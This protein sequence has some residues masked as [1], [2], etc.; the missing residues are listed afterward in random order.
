MMLYGI[1]AVGVLLFFVII[2]SGYVKASPDEAIL[3]SGLK[4]TAKIVIGKAAI[5]IPFLERKDRL[6]LK[7]MKIDVKTR[8]SVPTNEFINVNVDAVVTVKISSDPALIKLAAENFLNQKEQY[9]VD[10]VT[11]VLEGNIREIVGTMT[12]ENM[13]SDRQEFAKKV[14][15]NA[16]PD[17]RKMGIE[18]VSFN[19]QNFSDK[20]GI[21]EDLGI[22]NTTKIKKNAAIVRA[23]SERDVN[24]AQAMADKESNDAKVSA[25]QEIAI[26]QNQLAIKKAE[27]KKT[28]DIKKAEADMAYDIQ[29]EEQR[30]TMEI[31]SA[32][33]NLAKQEKEIELKEREVQIKEKTLEAEIKKK[34]EADR[35]AKQ[36]QADANLYERQKKAEAEKFEA[37]QQAEA[38]KAKAEAERVAKEEEAIGIK[39]VALAEADGIRAKG[40]AE[41]EGIDKKAE[42][43]QKMQE[44]AV[45][46]MYFKV[47]PEIAANVAKPLEKVDKITMYGEG[48]T[49][50]LVGDITKSA[51]QITD[52]LTDALGIDIKSFI[53]GIIGTKAMSSNTINTEKSIKNY[54]MNMDEIASD[55]EE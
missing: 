10:M 21:I 28:E 25:D 52:S 22:D 42:A 44:A 19:V 9:I 40:L 3:I 26:K 30:K 23:E 51:T 45:L 55:I 27:L 5:K 50:R 15:E 31:T 43:M 16:V 49:T 2:M 46:E 13:I 48:N 33:A 37:L 38:L 36:Q 54:E 47:L 29:K 8:E 7:I 24:M 20:N 53:A 1:I 39:A 41:A 18:I 4:K 12:L 32:N 6:T 17:M 14:Q 34:A 35:Y 11:D